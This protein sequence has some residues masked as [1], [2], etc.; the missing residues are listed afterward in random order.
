MRYFESPQQYVLN[1]EQA[2]LFLAGGICGCPDWQAEVVEML[3]Y[4][5]IDLI[6]PRRMDFPMHDP[7][8]AETQIKWEFEHL[9]MAHGILFWFPYETLCP[10]VLYELGAHSMT[11]RALFVGTHPKYARKQDVEIQTRLARPELVVENYLPALVQRVREWAVKL[12]RV[13][14]CEDMRVLRALD[15]AIEQTE[16]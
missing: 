4:D 8:A 9:R 16:K 12:A 1:P 5:P 14:A 2:C 6:N 10:I 11:H 13:T 3:K 15:Y 7:A